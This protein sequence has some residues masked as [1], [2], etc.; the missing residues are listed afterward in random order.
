MF[1][2]VILVDSLDNAN[3]IAKKINNKYRI[4][5]LTGEL[6][7]VGG[8]VTGGTIK[9]KSVISEKYELQNLISKKAHLILSRDKDSKI[10]EDLISKEKEK[11]V[12]IM[13]IEKNKILC[14]EELD[15]KKL[16]YEKYSKDYEDITLE[17]NNLNNLVKNNFSS[18]EDKIIT[19]D[20]EV[21]GKRED[22]EKQVKLVMD[23]RDKLTFEIDE[24]NAKY[25]TINS[26]LRTLENTL[27]EKEINNT[28][29]SVKMD[30][31]LSILSENYSI[32][33]EKA[34][35]NYIL[36]IDENI[37]RKTVNELKGI[38][39]K[40]GD[41]NVGSI[42]E[43]ERVNARYEFLTKQTNDLESAIS[44]LLNIIDE[45]DEVMKNEFL[46]T[47]KEIEVEFDKVFKDLFGGGEAKLKL[48]DKSNILETGI[49]IVVTPP[50]KKIS[51]IS[52]LSGGEK[53]LTAI[54]L[55]FAI[56]NVKKIPFC[57]FDEV[58]AA[59]DE[60]NVDKVGAYFKKYIGKTQLIIITHKKKTM[61][62]ANTLYGIT[63]QESGVS[64]LVSVKLVD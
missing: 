42:E 28:K 44:T 29:I 63:M 36:E 37:A 19:K 3:I 40:L 48:T 34:R 11:Q 57:L 32:T 56:L 24:I 62:Y 30:N 54:S 50:G 55:L 60:N 18:E 1:G 9:V 46:N 15:G 51:S 43:F 25:R 26:N 27:K 39:K 12:K 21:L 38:I 59:L 33:F 58:E 7:N 16:T 6:I 52:L 8:S 53:T 13:E 17:F 14:S 10:L 31:M 22:L 47:F 20:Y 64:K 2:N 35:A 5:T 45:L 41:V 49:D 4:V 23:L 61:E